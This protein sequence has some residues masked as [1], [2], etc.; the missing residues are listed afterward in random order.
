MGVNKITPSTSKWLLNPSISKQDA[1]D[2]F[3][4]DANVHDL[5]QSEM[6]SST[7]V[8][9]KSGA[10]TQDGAG[11]YDV[12][13]AAN[14]P[15]R[16]FSLYD[17][18][19]SRKVAPSGRRNVARASLPAT[20]QIG[21]KFYLTDLQIE[22]EW[23]NAADD[24]LLT[25]GTGV[26][27]WHPTGSGVFLAE[28]ATGSTIEEG[29]SVALV[30]TTGTRRIT[31]TTTLT[32]QNVKGVALH[33]IATASTGYVATPAFGRPC[34]VYVNGG[35]VAV[36]AG[37]LLVPSATAG[38]S[39]SVGPEPS[40]IYGSSTQRVTG[41]PRGCFAVALA[42]SSATEL[43]PALM[44]GFVGQGAVVRITAPHDAADFSHNQAG[45]GTS[46]YVDRD[47]SAMLLSAK[48][49]PN[50]VILSPW[51][52]VTTAGGDDPAQANADFSP[53]Q[54]ALSWVA[55]LDGRSNGANF[56]GVEAGQITI[57]TTDNSAA[58]TT[59]GSHYAERVTLTTGSSALL[60]QYVAGYHY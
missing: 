52:R 29:R 5:T 34:K 6:G 41:M 56:A 15:T 10:S 50:A 18:T 59:I 53:D 46:A 43:V 47:I 44:L 42:D 36:V 19:L 1:H 4:P 58:A 13:A 7:G 2:A 28:N 3:G 39:Q 35:V 38:V 55:R 14:T 37:D 11:V 45:A 51:L 32:Q 12:L 22:V 17:T 54:A 33:D 20:G 57:P 8:I 25:G 30:G 9:T 31:K 23:R 27:G 24:L 40:A 26:A 21:E 48:H 60:S 16:E 49:V